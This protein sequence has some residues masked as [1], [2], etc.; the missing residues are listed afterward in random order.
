[1]NYQIYLLV[2]LLFWG[3]LCYLVGRAATR[4]NRQAT[5]W[6]LLS[7]LLSPLAAYILLLFSGNPQEA[8]SL[9]EKE[10]RIRRQHPERTDIREAALNE[11]NCPHCGAVVNPITEDGLHSS[12]TE[13]WLL[14]CDQCQGIIEPDV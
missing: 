5:P 7:I 1:M 4:F 14:I 2:P 10:E 9:Q 13:P 12:E 3:F 8:L 11:M 6:I